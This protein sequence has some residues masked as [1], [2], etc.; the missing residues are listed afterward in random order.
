MLAVFEPGALN[1]YTFF[2]LI[3]LTLFVSRNLTLTHLSLSGSLNSLL[4]DLI[5]PTPGLA[6]SLL[7]PRTLAAASLFS[8]FI[9]FFSELSTS[10]LS[11]LEPYSHDRG[12]NIS[13]K[14][15]SSLLFLDVYAPSI[16]SFSTDGRTD[17]FFPS[18]LPSSKNFF[19]VGA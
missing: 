3:L 13:L 18:I 15:S 8:S 2:C 17:S 14:N 19:I 10:F 1:C 9:L 5:A 16:L 6:F 11:L 4:C 7:I 12:V